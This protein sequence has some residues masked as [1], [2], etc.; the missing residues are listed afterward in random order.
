MNNKLT[1]QQERE[2]QGL[3]FNKAFLK[4]KARVFSRGKSR[5][6]GVSWSEQENK[7]QANLRRKGTKTRRLGSSADEVEAARMYD[8]AVAERDGRYACSC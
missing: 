7:W 8:K 3:N 4:I 1:D 5:F 6:R 2:L